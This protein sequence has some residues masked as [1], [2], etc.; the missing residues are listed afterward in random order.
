MKKLILLALV[1]G[2]SSSSTAPRTGSLTMTITASGNGTPQVTVTGPGAFKKTL[3]SSATL[4]GLVPGS[5]AITATDVTTTDAIVASV[6]HPTVTGTPAT[7]TVG[8]DAAASVSYAARPG[9]GGLWVVGGIASTSS[10]ANGAVEYSVAQLHASS[11]ATPAVQ[12]QFPVTAGPNIDPNDIAIDGQG[13]LWVANDNSN[14]LVEYPASS[15]GASASP[16]PA[17]TLQLP[18]SSITLALAFDANGDLWAGNEVTNTIVEF[19]PGQLTTSGSPTPAVT[20]TATVDQSGTA[21]YPMAMRFD[22]HGNLWVLNVTNF[23]LTAYAASQLASSG[24]P[25]PSV[26]VKTSNGIYPYSMAFDASGNLWLPTI[27][28]SS[29]GTNYPASLVELSAASL[30]TSGT[31]TPA[32]TLTLPGGIHSLTTAIAF[33][34]S[35]DLWYSDFIHA[36]IAELVPAQL[37]ASGSVTPTVAIVYGASSLFYGTALAFNPHT[38]GLPL[39]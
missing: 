15:L 19:T 17:V 22:A 26:V 16:T 37:A 36:T 10:T 20:I 7:V 25:A 6:Y 21:G 14:T 5:Y 33:D 30:A 11:S 32:V 4:T 13:N 34:N 23:T 2:C 38:T 35:G 12:L 9:S 28:Y 24:T 8:G 27:G 31:P 39:H 3:T 29:S 18:A 1:V